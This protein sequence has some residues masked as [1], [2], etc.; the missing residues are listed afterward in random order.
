M[1]IRDRYK[2]YSNVSVPM[3]S[4]KST[5]SSVRWIM[6]SG[7]KFAI[8][9]S[10]GGFGACYQHLPDWQ[11]FLVLI[12]SL[13]A[14]ISRNLCGGVCVRKWERSEHA[15]KRHRVN[16]RSA[17]TCY[18]ISSPLRGRDCVNSG[19]NVLIFF[20]SMTTLPP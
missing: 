2:L 11:L 19:S 15:H 14:S 3:T 5:S 7:L 12:Y 13:N 6:L 1:C 10:A 4:R 17:A 20:E 9:R 8:R 18:A 16:C